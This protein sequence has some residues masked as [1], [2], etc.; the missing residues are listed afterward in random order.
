LAGAFPPS[1]SRIVASS[2]PSI[3]KV[4]SGL[5]SPVASETVV[6]STPSWGILARI[7]ARIDQR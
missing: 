6:A 4:F 1:L 5:E 7:D 2:S 3:S